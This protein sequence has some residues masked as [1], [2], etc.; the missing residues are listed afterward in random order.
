[1][2]TPQ[3]GWCLPTAALHDLSSH[4][5]ECRGHSDLGLP[6]SDMLT[7]KLRCA[8]HQLSIALQE[9]VDTAKGPV[10]FKAQRVAQ[11]KAQAGYRAAW[12]TLFM[13]SDTVAAAVAE[14]YG[15]TKAQLLDKEAS[16][17]PVR[18]ALGETHVIALTKRKLGDAG[19]ASCCQLVPRR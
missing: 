5:Q 10:G 19:L 9:G 2:P 4:L 11:Q 12:S 8:P 15:I 14:H 17:L 16:D 6:G 1:M 13:R 7:L 3:E 18:M